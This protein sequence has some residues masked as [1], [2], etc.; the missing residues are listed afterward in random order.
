MK[1]E[2]VRGHIDAPL[3]ES[4]VTFWTGQGVLKE[5][6]ARARAAD[7]VCV[8][9]D[10]DGRIVGVNTV[11]KARVPS[12][13]ER[14]FWRYR[15]FVEPEYGDEVH[16][17]LLARA[18]D[19]L[20][21]EFESH[22]AAGGDADDPMGLCF[23]LGDRAFA[24]RN[25]EAVWP[26]SSMMY[27]GYSPQGRQVRI[28]Y[29]RNAALVGRAIDW[30]IRPAERVSIELFARSAVTPDDVVRFWTA[31]ARMDPD[32]ARRRVP[33]VLAVAV[34]PDGQLA[35]VC[36]VYVH[37]FETLRAPVWVCRAFV[38]TTNRAMSVGANL[39]AAAV[40]TLEHRFTTGEDTRGTGVVM[41]QENAALRAAHPSAVWRGAPVDL[42]YVGVTA[43][44]HDI[45]LKWFPG[46]TVRT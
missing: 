43:R 14:R 26:A 19:A 32:E 36:S 10:D 27:A 40:T 12:I 1:V 35:G 2:V 7:A 30:D 34:D 41:V 4:L 37:E 23:M 22:L 25:P 45:R 13:G 29:F 20:E 38:R 42:A 5:P 31:E 16:H 44:G 15:R 46:A 33:E 39:G 11:Y 8:L 3:V 24:E 6:A 21:V 9:R 17:E 18:Y 28:R